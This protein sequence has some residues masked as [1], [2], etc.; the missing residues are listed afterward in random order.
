MKRTYIW[1]DGDVF[2]VLVAANGNVGLV[3]RTRSLRAAIAALEA[4]AV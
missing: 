3:N 1:L 4:L 2:E